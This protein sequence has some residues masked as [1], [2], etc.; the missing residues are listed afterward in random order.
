MIQKIF[1]S[2]VVLFCLITIASCIE[3]TNPPVSE[4]PPDPDPDPVVV[5]KPPVITN[6]SFFVAEDISDNNIIGQFIASDPEGEALTYK[7]VGAEQELFEIDAS[8]GYLSLTSGRSLDFESTRNHF[9]IVQIVDGSLIVPFPITINVQDINEPPEFTNQTFYVDENLNVTNIIGQVIVSDPE[10]ESL[11]YIILTSGNRLFEIDASSGELRLANGQYLDFENTNRH[12]LRIQARESSFSRSADITIEVIDN[13]ERP[14][15]ALGQSFLLRKD[16]VVPFL[17][18]QV[19]ASDEDGSVESFQIIAGNNNNY[20]SINNDGNI[21]LTNSFSFNENTNTQQLKIIA[22]DN[23]S[24]Q[25]IGQYIDINLTNFILTNQNFDIPRD[26]APDPVGTVLF[27][28]NIN[29]IQ[30]LSIVG[31]NT[32]N[33]FSID[34][35]GVIR[36]NGELDYR[37]RQYQLEIQAVNVDSDTFQQEVL[38]NFVNILFTASNWNFQVNEYS[39]TDTL[40]GLLQTY[41][42]NEIESFNIVNSPNNL[43]FKINE[44]GEISVRSL[45]DYNVTSHYSFQMQASDTNNYSETATINISVE[46]IGT[47][48]VQRGTWNLNSF[49]LNF[50]LGEGFTETEK[51]SIRNVTT[52]ASASW[53]N[54][55]GQNLF[56]IASNETSALQENQ[57]TGIAQP[58][59]IF[60]IYKIEENWP[61]NRGL[62]LGFVNLWMQGNSIV[63]ADMVVN[64]QEHNWISSG[65]TA[66]ETS[67]NLDIFLAH[68]FGSVLGL[69]LE[70]DANVVSSF[71]D[72][73]MFQS[74]SPIG[75]GGIAGAGEVTD[76]DAGNMQKHYQFGVD[77]LFAAALRFNPR[78][79]EQLVLITIEIKK[80]GSY[81]HYVVPPR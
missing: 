41:D 45:I 79:A 5:N 11:L 9:P 6:Q 23:S 67:F 7:I 14:I 42:S 73:I 12:V 57:I 72:S 75:V 18:G 81:E 53:N 10:N 63:H 17:L 34:N 61:T 47:E 58:D 2:L 66:T 21:S 43:P 37:L 16:Q 80:D 62:S 24:N 39:P 1:V 30:S 28:E 8:N 49:P 19:Q 36:T 27:S 40:V 52:N 3:V 68:N 64:Y 33:V 78:G 31:G 13:N 48:T 55:V 54:K 74:I 60:G 77:N 38:I 50:Y 65:Q 20:F 44:I 46:K 70:R 35:Q 51:A 59:D 56:E 25:S 71:S 76:L 26:G 69:A 15:I 4:E 32:G 22:V 29:Q